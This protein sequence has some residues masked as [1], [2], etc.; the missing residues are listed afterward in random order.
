M[1]EYVN[2]MAIFRN[3]EDL[4]R[5]DWELLQNGAVTLYVRPEVLAEDIEW[6]KRH[7]YRVEVTMTTVGYGD[8]SPRTSLGQMVAV[9]RHDHR[10]RYHCSPDRHCVRGTRTES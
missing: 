4:Q 6:L 3:D 10:L 7:D 5:L 2:G 1:T 9:D 8:L